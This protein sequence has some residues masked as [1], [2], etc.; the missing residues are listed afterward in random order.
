MSLFKHRESVLI[1]TWT[2]FL[3]TGNIL[4]NAQEPLELNTDR[5]AFTPSVF[6]VDPGTSLTEMSHVYIQNRNG[7]PTNNYKNY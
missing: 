4:V 6:C 7:L 5:D 3:A 1:F 2:F